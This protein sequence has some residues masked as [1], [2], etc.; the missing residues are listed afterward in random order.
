M[1]KGGQIQ[2]SFGMIFAI[3][4]IVATI[5]VAVYVINNFLTL[6]ACTEISQFYKNV[7]DRV[8]QAYSSDIT[9]DVVSEKLPSGIDFVCFGS[10]TQS[11]PQAFKQKYEEVRRY[12]KNGEN[13]VLYPARKACDLEHTSYTLK[14]AETRE[15][16]CIP[17]KEGKVEFKISFDVRLNKKVLI[18]RNG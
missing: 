13:I 11:A 8:E 2:L 14:H 15:F 12:L 4:I 5:A 7:N 1:N 16:F 18:A 10:Y 3:I 17:V 6:G 9:Q